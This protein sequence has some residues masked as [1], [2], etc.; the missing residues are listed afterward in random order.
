MEIVFLQQFCSLKHWQGRP[1]CMEMI[2]LIPQT[3]GKDTRP[4]FL[5][6]WSDPAWGG[7]TDLIPWDKMHKCKGEG[8]RNIVQ[9][10]KDCRGSE[11]LRENR[12]MY[13]FFITVQCSSTSECEVTACFNVQQQHL[14]QSAEVVK[15][16]Y[17]HSTCYF[18]PKCK[19]GKAARSLSRSPL[20]MAEQG[21]TR[22]REAECGS[23]FLRCFCLFFP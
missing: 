15:V 18:G 16:S 19:V 1:S 3:L 8:L 4:Y 12:K 9:L 17:S 22:T 20:K 2:Q 13:I 11:W 14:W 10:G 5:D 21:K 6:Q 23:V 7:K